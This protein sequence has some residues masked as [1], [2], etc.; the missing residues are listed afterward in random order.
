M[1]T[2]MCCVYAYCYAYLPTHDVTIHSY[3]MSMCATR[4]K[5]LIHYILQ[6]SKQNIILPSFAEEKRVGAPNRYSLL[7]NKN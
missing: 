3:N 2:L 6:Q 1:Y 5:P 4:Q 7:E